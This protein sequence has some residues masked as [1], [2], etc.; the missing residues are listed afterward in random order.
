MRRHKN[1]LSVVL[2]DRAV[3]LDIAVCA[4]LKTGSKPEQ[5]GFAVSGW[6]EQSDDP[7]KGC[8]DSDI[9]SEFREADGATHGQHERF[10]RP[11]RAH[12]GGELSPPSAPEKKRSTSQ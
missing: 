10:I 4:P 3:M 1:A 6:T 8:R 7:G 11:A 9:C 12:V 2:P 5:G